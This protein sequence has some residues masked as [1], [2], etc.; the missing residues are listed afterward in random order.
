MKKSAR[1]DRVFSLKG[2]RTEIKRI[3]WPK[4][5]EITESSGTVIVFTGAFAI[6]FA[7]CTFISA[8]LFTLL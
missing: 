3:R 5:K 7:L 8:E 6:F 1:K 2:I 4:P